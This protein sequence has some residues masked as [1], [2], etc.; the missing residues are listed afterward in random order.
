MRGGK[1]IVPRPDRN[2]ALAGV[3]GEAG[4]ADVLIEERFKLVVRRH[5]VA[6][7]AFLVEPDPLVSRRSDFER[8]NSVST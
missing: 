1:P 6:L 2:L 4:G 5:L 8:L 3:A 7:A